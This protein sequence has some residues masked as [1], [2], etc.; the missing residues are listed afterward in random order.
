MESK[1]TFNDLERYR[2]QYRDQMPERDGFTPDQQIAMTTI[3][4]QSV[5]RGSCG[6]IAVVLSKQTLRVLFDA[7]VIDE[8][9]RLT[10]RGETI[11]K[12][13]LRG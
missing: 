9:C 4:N 2:Q 10:K 13:W 1:P 5:S 12:G 3:H 11:L 7:K 8:R 6:A